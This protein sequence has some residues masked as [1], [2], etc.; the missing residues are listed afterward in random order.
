MQKCDFG[1]TLGGK[2][3]IFSISN[4]L[5]HKD[6]VLLN[7]RAKLKTRPAK[8]PHSA[9]LHRYDICFQSSYIIP[10]LTRLSVCPSLQFIDIDS[11]RLPYKA[12]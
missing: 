4:V 2:E 1:R 5:L 3:S 12:N 11:A 9:L 10:A 6:T 8:S 7:V